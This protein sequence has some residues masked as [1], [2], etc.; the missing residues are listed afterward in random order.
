M[1]WLLAGTAVAVGLAGGPEAPRRAASPSPRVA[2]A[3]FALVAVA[4]AGWAGG[5][6]V[7]DHRLR[8][9]LDERAAGLPTEALFMLDDAPY[10]AP[11]RFDILQARARLAE[12]LRNSGFEIDLTDTALADLDDALDIAPGDP[13]LLVDRGSVL[14]SSGRLDEARRAYQAVLDGPYP[15]SSRAW[16]GLGVVAATEGD[17]SEAQRSW[18]RAADLAPSDERPWVNLGLLHEQE[19]RDA[20]AVAAFERA[21]EIEPD[22]RLA[23]AGL[24]RLTADD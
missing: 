1:A 17:D 11:A 13:D 5:E 18:A 19:G 24:E 8:D 6:L 9:A 23:A 16:L 7:A 12:E 4:G 22:S 10:T 2:V 20:Q 3:V 21:L 15:S 14:A